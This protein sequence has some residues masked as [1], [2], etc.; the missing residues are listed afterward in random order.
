MCL[1][2]KKTNKTK[3]N[4]QQPRINSDVK[5]G[6]KLSKLWNIQRVDEYSITRDVYIKF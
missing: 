2:Q 5:L 1:W 6:D 3:Q 4:N